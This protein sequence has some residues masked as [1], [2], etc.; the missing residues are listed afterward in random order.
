M[1]G[2]PIFM[3]KY[4]SGAEDEIFSE[5]QVNNMAANVKAHADIPSIAVVLTV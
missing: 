3:L 2:I 5:N 4:P 1:P